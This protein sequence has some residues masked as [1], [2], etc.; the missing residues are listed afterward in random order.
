MSTMYTLNYGGYY[1][2]VVKPGFR[3]IGLNSNVCYIYNWSVY[4]ISM[5]YDFNNHF[6]LLKRWL[7]YN[8]IDPFQQLNWLVNILAEVEIKNEVVHILSHIPPGDDTC[9]AEWTRQYHR[10]IERY[11]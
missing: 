5:L 7:L 11:R 6:S 8:D 2:Q 3:I 10:I 1:T 4:A 9:I